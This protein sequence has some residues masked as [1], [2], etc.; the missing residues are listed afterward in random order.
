MDNRTE[1]LEMELVSSLETFG[2]LYDQKAECLHRVSYIL[3]Q[4]AASVY[5]DLCFVAKTVACLFG[6]FSGGIF[7][8]ISAL[9]WSD[10][11]A[12]DV[13]FG[14]IGSIL[15]GVAGGALGG[16]ISGAGTILSKLAGGP[17]RDVTSETAGLFGFA[18]GGVVGG[19][20]GGPLGSTGGALGGVLGAFW[21]VQCAINPDGI[22]VR[23]VLDR[24]KNTETPLDKP[25]YDD[26]ARCLRD[27]R[28][29]IRLLMEQLKYIQIIC[30]K[31]ASDHHVHAIATQSAVSLDALAKME[32]V[33]AKAWGNGMFEL[34]SG[35]LAAAKL[36]RNVNKTLEG[37][38]RS[39]ETFLLQLNRTPEDLLSD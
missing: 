14:I 21:A 7:G 20:I 1:E 22:V 30:N 31:L 11:H 24:I 16:A 27:F 38:R 39:V 2:R 5:H 12:E 8:T 10:G 19:A 6:G 25:V 33:I 17:V 32:V 9:V 26:M 13:T 34:D 37:L 18:A 29:S 4:M 28:N 23:R 15:G 35:V 36:S 3:E